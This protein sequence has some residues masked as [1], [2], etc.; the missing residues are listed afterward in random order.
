MLAEPLISAKEF[1]LLL[2]AL[3]H[4]LK[5]AAEFA[6]QYT[7]EQ[8]NDCLHSCPEALKAAARLT[9]DIKEK[10]H[11]IEAMEI[12][13]QHH[14]KLSEAFQ[15]IY[16]QYLQPLKDPN[17]L[18]KTS[19]S[20][21]EDG[22]ASKNRILCQKMIAD[23]Q[24]Q[25]EPEIDK[26]TEVLKITLNSDHISNKNNPFA[27]NLLIES[28]FS[29][30]QSEAF[31]DNALHCLL[32]HFQASWFF[33]LKPFY[34][35]LLEHFTQAGVKLPASVNPKPKI[36]LSTTDS[37]FKLETIE[38]EAHKETD[39][40][41]DSSSEQMPLTDAI[42]LIQS[43]SIPPSIKINNYQPKPNHEHIETQLETL[44]F[45]EI[46]KHMCWQLMPYK[47]FSCK[48]SKISN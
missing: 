24:R 38:P 14:A 45:H 8:F 43:A 37:G 10:E 46:S 3:N 20:Q 41:S 18:A 13:E 1:E 26:S 2:S 48:P 29:T 42:S 17:Q 9:D 28:C 16:L 4:D 31:S 19:S 35:G 36:D 32:E 12:A 21:L 47:N 34:T 15:Q 30:L 33:K 39:F 7:H 5:S 6:Y 22:I 27:P 11:Y 23:A 44:I 25:F 40:F